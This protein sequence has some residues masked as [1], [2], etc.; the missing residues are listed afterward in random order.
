[1]NNQAQVIISARSVS[2]ELPWK[3]SA[4]G[5][6]FVIIGKKEMEKDEAK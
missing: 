3:Q 6:P 4:K 2:V 5:E 1:M